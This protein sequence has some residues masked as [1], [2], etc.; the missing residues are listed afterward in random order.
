VS[1][2]T[3]TRHAVESN[4]LPYEGR[5]WRAV[6]AQHVISTLA[7]V[8]T[9]EEQALLEQLLEKSKP[10]VPPDAQHLHYLLATPFR[11]P[12]SQH[13]SRFRAPH[14]LGVFYAAE[15]VRTACA[16]LGYWRWRFLM[17]STLD[18][19][20]SISQSV[21][22]SS[23][24]ATVIDLRIAPFAADRDVWVDP[25]SHLGCQEFGA[26]VRETGVEGILYE[27]VRDPQRGQCVALLQ[28]SGF[29]AAAPLELQ[30]W[31]LAVTRSRVFWQRQ[32]AITPA[33]FEFNFTH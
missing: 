2:T 12:P 31:S 33:S 27:S 10:P 20:P 16:E 22:Q 4:T 19:I 6:E 29:R 15:Q 9:L 23:I 7:L 17:D 1:S 8:D 26:L 11:Y 32:S 18:A 5:P 21:F 14:A 13:G 28:A 25:H 3:W 24:V 30:T